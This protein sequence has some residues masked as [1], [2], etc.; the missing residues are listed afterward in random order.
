[1]LLPAKAW[2]GF[3]NAGVDLV[4]F[5]GVIYFA[6]TDRVSQYHAVF[7]TLMGIRGVL[8]PLLGGLVL[9][10]HLAEHAGGVRDIGGDDLCER[11]SPGDRLSEV[12]PAMGEHADQ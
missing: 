3:I 6:P 2:L 11:G 12:L 4:Y 10:Y 8:A 1:M 7:T 5:T 9:Q